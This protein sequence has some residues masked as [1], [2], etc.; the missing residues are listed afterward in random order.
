MRAFLAAVDPLPT[1]TNLIAGGCAASLLSICLVA[2]GLFDPAVTSLRGGE[3]SRDS[4]GLPAPELTGNAWVNL[5]KGSRLT[6]AS[7]KGKVTIVHFW[8]YNC[9]NCKHNLPAYARWQKRFAASGVIVIGI[10]S[11]E[12]EAERNPTNVVRKVKELG[13]TY[14]VLIDSER[15]NWKR[16]GQHLW[17][18]ICLIDKQGKAR[19]GWEGELEYRGANG[20]A[21][22]TRLIEALLKE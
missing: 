4:A 11:P 9:I 13:I 7:R 22:M 16:W 19:Y 3:P 20:E 18:A 2:L 10:H 12:S 6:L 15:E 14:P 1:C 8:T 17:P 5:P 21:K